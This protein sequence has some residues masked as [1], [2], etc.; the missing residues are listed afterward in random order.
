M[1]EFKP[2]LLAL[3]E[4]D[5]LSRD[6]AR[7]AFALILQGRVTPMQLAAFLMGLR[8]RGETV[9][10][11]VGAAQAMRAAMTPV[12]APADAIDI[13]GTGGD[14]AG[15]FNIST[16]AS[17]IV[18]ACGVRVAK[19]GGKAASSLSGASD[20]LDQLGV[21]VGVDAAASARCLADA[22]ICFM[23]SPA[24]H[25][26]MRFAAPV[27]S[28][29]GL[30]T[31]FNMLGP[32]C[33]PAGVTRQVVGVFSQ[34]WLEPLAQALAELGS[35]RVWLLHGSDGLDEATTTATTCV[36]SLEGGAIRSFEI[37]PEDAGLPRCEPQALIGG[38]PAHNAAALRRVLDGERGA[39]RDIAVMNA[40]VALIVAE[41]AATLREGAALATQALDSGRARE[42]LA[43]LIRVSNA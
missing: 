34:R 20:V 27:R 4:G 26:A 10:E 15:T 16:L 1:T 30:R 13:V 35:Q 11:I 37:S 12:S 17:I 41:K 42:T 38:D 7:E 33:N 25:P 40:A 28:E 2:Y 31:I 19:H 6:E 22:G 8:L 9:E 14:G 24:H 18:A 36:V 32:I 21:R 43:A 5:P 39:Y 29:L 3:A 23:A